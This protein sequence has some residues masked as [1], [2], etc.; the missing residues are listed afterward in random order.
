MG[1]V[2]EGREEDR[3]LQCQGNPHDLLLHTS[4]PIRPSR[5]I[6]HGP[7]AYKGEVPEEVADD[8]RQRRYCSSG[9]G[10]EAVL[11]RLCRLKPQSETM[12]MLLRVIG[13]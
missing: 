7:A 11:G 9:K 2:E 10:R 3:R 5:K 6:P 13:E 12:I 4:P 8:G 1:R